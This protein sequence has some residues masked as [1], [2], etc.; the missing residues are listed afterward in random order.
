M[1]SMKSKRRQKAAPTTT[2]S[3]SRSRSRSILMP[4]DACERVV[5]SMRVIAERNWSSKGGGIKN[6]HAR[7]C[8]HGVDA[9]LQ[10]V[11]NMAERWVGDETMEF[12]F[13]PST[14]FRPKHFDE[15]L[16]ARRRRAV[17]IEDHQQQ[18]FKITCRDCGAWWQRTVIV[19]KAA[20]YHREE[21]SRKHAEEAFASAIDYIG[22]ECNHQVSVIVEPLP[23]S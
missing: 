6:L 10:V 23:A 18:K 12:Y 17:G 8:E 1:A 19:P 11:T 7:H 15:Y 22:H 9:C 21:W 5:A 14:L 16:N 20:T 4:C 3:S 13:R 2:R